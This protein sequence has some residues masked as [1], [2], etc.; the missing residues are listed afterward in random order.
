M[1][2]GPQISAWELVSFSN[3]VYFSVWDHDPG[4][5]GIQKP[6]HQDLLQDLGPATAVWD[7]HVALSK[8]GGYQK[9]PSN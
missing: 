4:E 9:T 3:S 2:K 1:K 5:Y 7:L 6:N 8:H